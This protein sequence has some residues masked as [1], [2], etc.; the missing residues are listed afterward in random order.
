MKKE[1]K[2]II[3]LDVDG[4]LNSQE[5]FLSLSHEELSEMPCEVFDRP[6]KLLKQIIDKT[7][8]KVVI[9]SSW[10]MTLFS[11]TAVLYNKLINKLGE[12]NIKPISVTPMLSGENK[13]RG[14]E[15][16]AWLENNS[17][18]THFIILDDDSDMCEFTENNLVQTTYEYG[19]R[20]E[21]VKKAIK[22]LSNNNNNV[23]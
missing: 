13:Q 15:I 19:L 21:H 2:K 16:R 12:F 11:G 5:D 1:N 9:S 6:L 4:V 10:R 14:D 22:I 3:F 7:G 8:A 20:E 18:V 17:D 23:D